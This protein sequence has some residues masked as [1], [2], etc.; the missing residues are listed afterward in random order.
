[1]ATVAAAPAQSSVTPSYAASQPFFVKLAWLLSAII[2]VGFAQHAALGRVNIPAVPIW[3]HF[4]GLLML[5]WLALFIT[6]NRLA[7]SGNLALHRKLG[8]IG[9]FL[10]CA[11]AGLA[12]FTGTMSLVLHRYPP[13]FTAPFFLALTTIDTTAFVGLVLAGI[14]N[15]G[16]TETHR[17][18]I[19]GGTILILEPAFGRLLPMPL[20]GGE[21]GEWI[22]MA[23][24]L[25]FVA[26]IARHDRRTL[27]R[28]HNATVSVAVVVV[29]AHLV[30]HFAAQSGP[31]I[32]LAQRLGG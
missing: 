5:S 1:M 4:H 18:L 28:I 21:T 25:G 20:I 9:A 32:A 14:V 26:A 23:I 3:V 12:Y 6:Q 16:D 17:R 19:A 22:V 29:L 7:A 24:Q 13:F 10:I 8:W 30:V 2:V 31:V 27:G 11:I 15:R